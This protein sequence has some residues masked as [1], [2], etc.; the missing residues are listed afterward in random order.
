ML[1]G[2][3]GR[4]GAAIAEALCQA[5][6]SVVLVDVAPAGLQALSASLGDGARVVS[7]PLDVTQAGAADGAI[8]VALEHFGR[9]DGLVNNAGVEGP[10]ARIEDIAVEQVRRVFDVNVFAT[11]EFSQAAIRHFRTVGSGRIVNIAS[12]AGTAGSA[13]MTPYSASK[14]AVL[15]ITRS[16]AAEVAGAGIQVNAVCPGCID[17]PMMERIEARLGEL[18]GSGGPVSFISG[19]PAGR[20]AAPAEIARIVAYLA[21]EAPDYVTGTGMV[22]DGGMRA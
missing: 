11:L 18:M 9:L 20:Y 8:E 1:T 12:G 4:L 21:L 10:V 15:G 22:V 3:G 17:S 2:A 5:G 14:H 6:A 16:I 13:Y 7:L 19:I